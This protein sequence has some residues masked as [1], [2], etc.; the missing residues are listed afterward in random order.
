M[1][2]DEEREWIGGLCRIYGAPAPDDGLHWG[3]DLGNY[4]LHWERHTEFSTLTLIAPGG[5]RTDPFGDPVADLLP[6]EWVGAIPGMLIAGCHVTFLSLEDDLNT[7]EIE[8][9][10]EGQRLIVT[11]VMSGR[12]TI[13]TALRTHGDGFVRYLVVDHGM[14]PQQLGRLAQRLIELDTYRPMALLGLQL[15]RTIAPLIS[16]ME[17]E[18][19]SITADLAEQDN[20]VTERQMLGRL[21]SLAGRGE[22]LQARSAFRFGATE[23]YGALVAD[24]IRELQEQRVSPYQPLGEFLDRRFEPALRYCASIAGRQGKL[25][26]RIAR[27]S[28]LVRT[29]VDISL[30]EQNQQLLRSIQRR[31]VQQIRLQQTVE[32]LSVVA[33]SYYGVGLLSYLL[34]GSTIWGYSTTTID[35][36]LAICVPI[37]LVALWLQVRRY[38]KKLR[39]RDA[40][41]PDD[42]HGA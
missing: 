19:A 22:A 4:R 13:W 25:S 41:D 39:L 11:S 23:A 7:R 29:R 28:G 30:Q 6:R 15:A 9:A 12:A 21:V 42:S 27:T 24:R 33:I 38:R 32:G 34:K 40:E 17:K 35:M 10:F 1:S 31:A 18:L 8:R 16:Q 36:V 5:G 37:V 20:P 14:E 2:V 26:E 3:I